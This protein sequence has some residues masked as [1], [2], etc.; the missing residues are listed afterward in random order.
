MKVVV[1]ST[2]ADKQWVFEGTQWT[3][4]H[5]MLE[6]F[7]WLA[8]DQAEHHG[9]VDSMVAQLDSSQA[10]EAEVVEEP[11]IQKSTAPGGRENYQYSGPVEHREHQAGNQTALHMI[12]WNPLTHPAFRAAQFLSGKPA[13]SE[14]AAKKAMYQNSDYITAALVAYGLP[15]HDQSKASVE[16]IMGLENTSKAEPTPAVP[17]GKDIVA[18]TSDG[19]ETAEA[20]RQA[21]AAGTVEPAHLD[22]KHSRGSFIA[23]C[24]EADRTF[25]LK[26]GAGGPGPQAGA[27]DTPA[28]P[29]RREAAF[30]HVADDWGLG[31]SIP[32]AELV[33]ID[34]R[35]YAAITMLP[36]SWNG[37]QWAIDE[38]ERGSTSK[39]LPTMAKYRDRG[40]LHKWAVLDF[41]LGQPDRHGDNIMVSEDWRLLA[42]IDHGSAF[43]GPHFNPANDQ[44]SFV[45]YY[46]RAWSPAEWRER[47]LEQK[48]KLMPTANGKT[49]EE[50]AEWLEGLH[51]DQLAG[52]LTRYGIDPAPELERLGKVK[53]LATQMPVDLAINRLWATV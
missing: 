19:E 24:K 33:I 25:L 26:P 38:K 14:E 5:D 43:A 15:V 46:L 28:S 36:F 40:L 23:R 13:I 22:G 30:Y 27:K 45:P 53:Q 51:A 52:V 9:D 29:S 50:L 31:E 17:A 20:L 16:A 42:L 2:Y 7:P 1:Y 10:F 3:V 11:S 41:V 32:E 49:R 37:L 39:V 35:E 44:N 18:A 12:G 6:S 4:Y 47:S 34:G 8:S 48:L 21:F